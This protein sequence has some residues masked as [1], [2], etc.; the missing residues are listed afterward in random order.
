[1]ARY[2]IMYW[3]EFPSQVKAED[4][5]GVAKAMLSQRFQEAIDLAAMAEGSAD[6]AAYLEGWHWGPEQERAG[7]A[8]EVVDA[9][10]AELEEAYPNERLMQMVHSR[11]GPP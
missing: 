10:V 8:Q 4:E 2:Q 5:T 11:S 7:S 9:L 6:S 1:M 3:K